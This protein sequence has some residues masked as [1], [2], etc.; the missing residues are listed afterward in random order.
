MSFLPPLDATLDVKF[1]LDVKFDL[2]HAL[3]Q[4]RQG[5]LRVE[6]FEVVLVHVIVHIQSTPYSFVHGAH[7]SFR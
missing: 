4:I 6:I 1:A 3:E 2:D 7:W 5:R